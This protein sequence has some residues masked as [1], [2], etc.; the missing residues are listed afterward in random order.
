MT[1]TALNNLEQARF[2][3]VEQQIRTWEVLDQSVLDLLFV[4][5][6][7][8]FVPPAYRALAFM[9]TE[10]PLG[11][12][13]IEFDNQTMMT[14]KLEARIIQELAPKSHERVLEIG[15]GSGYLT[16]L[17]AKRAARVASIEYFQTLAN[18]AAGKLAGAG[19]GNVEITV[20]DAAISP[21]AF[22]P[23]GQTFEVIVLTGSTPTLP[24]AF[25][26]YLAIGGR[27]FAVIGDAPVMKATLI[28]KT[29]ANAYATEVLFETVLPPLIHAQQPSR[30]TF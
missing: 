3:M 20:G 14:P 2:N 6:R 13:G 25:L 28:R 1:S 24:D 17:L 12:E 30:F 15:T 5:K 23:A 21:A 11:T 8:D 9:D 22:L 27:M 7:E 18:Q 16:A 26:P 19:I 4:V 10:I 29:A